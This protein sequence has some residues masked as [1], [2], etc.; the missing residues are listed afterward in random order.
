MKTAK[1]PIALLPVSLLFGILTASAMDLRVDGDTI[2]MA[3]SVQGQDYDRFISVFNPSVHRVVFTNSP[4]GDLAAAYNVA[5]EIRLRKLETSVKGYCRSACALMFL[6]GVERRLVDAKSYVAFHSGYGSTMGTPTP[7]QYGRIGRLLTEMTGG[8]LSDAV[9]EIILQKRRNGFV[10][11]YRD[12]TY[13]CD[14]TE[15]KRPS[16][17]EKI[18][19]TAMEQGILTSLGDVT[20][21]QVKLDELPITSEHARAE[22]SD[23]LEETLP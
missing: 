20:V 19:Q 10:Y 13:N 16:G 15:P 6:G 23:Y 4:G 8:K 18:P 5:E 12:R 7:G 9:V 21:I 1:L 11:F 17:C 2:Y 3:G 22:Y 14:G